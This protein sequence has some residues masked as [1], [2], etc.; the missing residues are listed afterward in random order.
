ME[1]YKHVQ[2][3]FCCYDIKSAGEAV[4][5]VLL[6]VVWNPLLIEINVSQIRTLDIKRE[7]VCAVCPY[8]LFDRM[9]KS[10]Q[11]CRN[12]PHKREIRQNKRTPISSTH[13]TS[14]IDPS[15]SDITDP[16]TTLTRKSDRYLLSSPRESGSQPSFQTSQL[17]VHYRKLLNADL[18]QYV[19]IIPSINLL[20]GIHCLKCYSHNVSGIDSTPVFRWKF[21]VRTTHWRSQN[22]SV[23]GAHLPNHDKEINKIMYKNIITPVINI[24]GIIL[25]KS[26]CTEQSLMR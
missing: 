8:L 13:P 11:W 18:Q 15:P 24:P 12:V 20:D 23:G 3:C 26:D 5:K 21:V 19:Y 9:R 25:Q 10:Y 16:H 7:K 6:S 2:Y 1:F 22:I 17:S 14:V 4:N